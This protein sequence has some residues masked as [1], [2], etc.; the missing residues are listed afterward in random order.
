VLTFFFVLVALIAVTRLFE[1]TVSN[2]HR[3]ALVARGAPPIRDP[4]FAAMAS[5][6]AGVL[7]G[8]VVEVLVIGRAVPV[9][10][11]LAAAGGVLAANALRVWAMRTLGMHWNVRVVDSAALGVVTSGP[12]RFVRHPNY[13]AV[14]AELA[15][16]PMVHAAWFTAA[17]GTALHVIVLRRRIVL[18]ESILFRNPSYAVAMRHKPRFLPRPFNRGAELARAEP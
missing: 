6:H 8:S 3:R 4:G 13:L 1:L 7:A 18:E 10:F 17:L 15:L 12:Y 9:W 2:R 14:F 16:L 5:L 11:G